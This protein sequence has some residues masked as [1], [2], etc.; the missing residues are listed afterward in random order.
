MSNDDLASTDAVPYADDPHA[1]VENPPE[2]ELVPLDEPAPIVDP[3]FVGEPKNVSGRLGSTGLDLLARR[4]LARRGIDPAAMEL[5][6][7]GSRAA[8]GPLEDILS[9][10]APV[11]AARGRGTRS[12]AGRPTVSLESVILDDDGDGRER[13]FDTDHFPYSAIAALEITARDGSRY[14]GT[15]WFVSRFT[16]ITAGHCVFVRNAASPAANGWVRSIRVVPGRNGTGPGS[17]PFGAAVATRFRSVAGW[18][19]DGSPGSD[20]GAILLEPDAA[21]DGNRVGVFGIAALGD[22]ALGG[23]NLNVAGYP[24]DKQGSEAQTLWF[25]VKKTA[26]LTARQ[27][28]YNADTFGGQSGA[29]VYVVAPDGGDERVAVAVHAYGT[30]AGISSNSGTRITADVFQRIQSWKT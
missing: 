8:Q 10:S 26:R 22:A 9:A 12:I 23:R 5:E 4:V 6:S 21:V 15:G 7:L 25:D 28:F 27:V 13:V 2:A 1:S 29:P 24:G 11:A 18:V 20:Y 19:K 16:L 14:L 3:G 30:S 17:E